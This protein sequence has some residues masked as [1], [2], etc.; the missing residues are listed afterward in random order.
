MRNSLAKLGCILS[1]I[2]SFGHA[3]AE[4]CKNSDLLIFG[5][6]L[7]DTGNSYALSPIVAPGCGPTPPSPPYFHGRFSNGPNWVDYTSQNLDISVENYAVGGAMSNNQNYPPS[8]IY[9][10]LG[11]LFQQIGRF[12]QADGKISENQTVILEIGNNDFLN[13][14]SN[15]TA[16]SFTLA[17]L[18]L[19]GDISETVPVIQ[20]FGAERI[21]VWNLPPLGQAPLFNNPFFGLQNTGLNVAYDTAI[22]AYNPQLLSVVRSLNLQSEDH[23]TVFYFDVNQVFSDIRQDFINEGVNPFDTQLASQLGLCN[24]VA[25]PLPHGP[26][27][28][29]WDQVHPATNA[30]RRFA[31]E[32][33]AYLDTIDNS[34]RTIGAQHDVIAVDY[35][36]FRYLLDNHFRTL[37]RQFY[38]CPTDCDDCCEPACYQVYTDGL[39]KWGKTRNGCGIRGFHYD[40]QLV[41]LGVDYFLNNCL[42]AGVAFNA[43]RNNARLFHGDDVLLNEYIPTFYA[44]YTD[45]CFFADFD[46]SYRYLYFKKITRN[47]PFVCR[48]LHAHA[49]GWG[50]S[51]GLQGGYLYNCA[52]ITTGPIVGINYQS[53]LI[54]AYNEKGRR[55]PSLH[56]HGQREENCFAKL[57]WQLFWN[58]C[59]C[60]L[61][62]Y[63]EVDYYYDFLHHRR[64]IM[65]NFRHMDDRA[66]IR[67]KVQNNR[68]RNFL[69]YNLGVDFGV[70]EGITGNVSYQGE[71]TFHNY[72]NTVIA[73]LDAKF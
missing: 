72:N 71:T 70:W 2:A 30:W 27:T 5:N 37:H 54:H 17:S 44:T 62:P 8:G 48:K 46:I 61:S 65:S 31:R 47:I 53:A 4:E 64:K 66:Q 26:E 43:Q 7:S 39:A 9:A 3:A 55:Y 51:T 22:A 50:I 41:G 60:G 18:R 33:S 57:G 73:E 59:D 45:P 63:A 32:M 12:Q 1:L 40:T 58:E 15:P 16:A 25:T 29:F 52:C 68:E 6:S 49:T 34:H 13:V 10:G 14:L 23:K 35:R 11:G 28:I 36:A 21:V 56:V 38:V 67:H 19:L 69:T 20:D 42:T 24:P